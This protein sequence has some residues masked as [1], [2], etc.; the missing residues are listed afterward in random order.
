M[1]KIANEIP[2]SSSLKYLTNS[3]K[4]ILAAKRKKKIVIELSSMQV[5]SS[6]CNN[7]SEAENVKRKK[8]TTISSICRGLRKR[9]NV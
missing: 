1:A 6:T 2:A 8:V 7:Q 5:F 4:C 9:R 3:T